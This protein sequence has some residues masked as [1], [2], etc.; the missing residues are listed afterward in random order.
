MSQQPQHSQ[1]NPQQQALRPQNSYHHTSSRVQTPALECQTCIRRAKTSAIANITNSGRLYRLPCGHLQC[2]ACLTDHYQRREK[3]SQVIKCA[4][5]NC[6]TGFPY[7]YK[8]SNNHLSLF[9]NSAYLKSIRDKHILDPRSPNYAARDTCIVDH[10]DYRVIFS[11]VCQL[12]IMQYPDLRME[13]V[14]SPMPLDI[15]HV[16]YGHFAGGIRV[17]TPE[18][19]EAEMGILLGGVLYDRWFQQLGA[20]YRG[21]GIALM[22]DDADVAFQRQTDFLRGLKKLE[23]NVARLAQMWEGIIQWTAAAVAVKWWARFG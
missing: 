17:T 14:V 7:A 1:L 20:K 13:G 9:R 23:P 12:A 16:L 2:Q 19:F 22:T 11:E 18:L 4:A 3:L 5:C 6:D 10:D 8:M 15:Y 21:V